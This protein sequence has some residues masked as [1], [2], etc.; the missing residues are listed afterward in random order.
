M[1]STSYVFE[2]RHRIRLAITS[3]EFPTAFP[4]PQPGMNEVFHGGE[5][6]S[7]IEL[8]VLAQ[9]PPMTGVYLKELPP[10][11]IDAPSNNCYEVNQDQS[12][13][14]WIASR[15]VNKRYP[16]LEGEIEWCQ[17]TEARVHPDHPAEASVESCASFRFF[18]RSG[19]ECASVGEVKCRGD[20]RSIYVNASLRVSVNGVETYQRDWA[21]QYPRKF[22]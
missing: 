6:L 12:T 3:A 1:K 20:D 13:G 21:H 16:G 11:P 22:V 10:P 4:T 2:P 17:T 18:Y 19:E 8:P 5:M 14:Q 9:T 15:K 7:W